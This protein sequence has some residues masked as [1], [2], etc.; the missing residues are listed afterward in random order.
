MSKWHKNGSV[1]GVHPSA[2]R[3]THHPGEPHR[4]GPHPKAHG[5]AVQ[6]DRCG[7]SVATEALQEFHEPWAMADAPHVVHTAELEKYGLVSVDGKAYA[8]GFERKSDRTVSKVLE[9]LTLALH[10]TAMDRDSVADAFTSAG[11]TPHRALL[12]ASLY[13][14]GRAAGGDCGQAMVDT[15]NGKATT[16]EKPRRPSPVARVVAWV[17]PNVV[18]VQREFGARHDSKRLCFAYGARDPQ[19]R[20]RRW[21]DGSPVVV[22]CQATKTFEGY[23]ELYLVGVMPEEAD[24]RPGDYL[25]DADEVLG[26]A[27]PRALMRRTGESDADF[28]RRYQDHESADM[29]TVNVRIGP[30]I[31]KAAAATEAMADEVMRKRFPAPPLPGGLRYAPSAQGD[32]YGS[33][34]WA[35]WSEWANDPAMRADPYLALR[36]ARLCG[37]FQMGP[38]TSLEKA[39]EDAR[40]GLEIGAKSM[41][42]LDRHF[43]AAMADQ[44][45][46]VAAFDEVVKAKG[47]AS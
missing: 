7:L 27:E 16:Q 39:I 35:A 29:M 46:R 26:R 34:S 1:G 5:A 19:A 32:T 17:A 28:M 47:G 10:S 15:L 3:D 40:H 8:K 24:S 21:H 25:W 36:I 30:G 37:A 9:V 45:A 13:V 4:F 38:T 41:A 42:A 6:C 2:L 20:M 11:A 14:N 12:A 18:R 23:D 22:V 44:D 31:E 43:A 33:R